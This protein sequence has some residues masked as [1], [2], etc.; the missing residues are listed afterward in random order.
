MTLE[1]VILND[2]GT[3]IAVRE[4]DLKDGGNVQVT[5]GMPREFP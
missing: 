4:L 5:I 3:V 2:V 1:D